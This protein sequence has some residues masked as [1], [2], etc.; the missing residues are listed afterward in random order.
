MLIKSTLI[1][2]AHTWMAATWPLLVKKQVTGRTRLLLSLLFSI[3]LI[4]ICFGRGK[5]YMG[6][7]CRVRHTRY[8][9]LRTGQRTRQCYDIW[10][11]VQVRSVPSAFVCSSALCG[12][13]LGQAKL[14]WTQTFCKYLFHHTWC[15]SFT[16]W[17]LVACY[18]D[19]VRTY[20][21]G[22]ND[23]TNIFEF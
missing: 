12:Q 5:Q 6:L 9:T 11:S 8:I 21:V 22:E 13:V 20:C 3:Q 1:W 10:Q 23:T 16:F 19:D 17:F 4:K 15:L 2:K 7:Q 18:R 14:F